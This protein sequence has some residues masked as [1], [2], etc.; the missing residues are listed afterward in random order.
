MLQWLTQLIRLIQFWTCLDG[1]SAARKALGGVSRAKAALSTYN[2]NVKSGRCLE[3]ANRKRTLRALR[4][5]TFRPEPTMTREEA[6]LE[7]RSS[8]CLYGRLY[9]CAEQKRIEFENAVQDAVA[10]AAEYDYDIDY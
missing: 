2:K 5:Y 4:N 8:R 9:T 7:L 3:L 6:A 10:A 1:F